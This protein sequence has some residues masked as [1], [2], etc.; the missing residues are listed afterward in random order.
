MTLPVN[1]TL[2][3]LALTRFNKVQ[4]GVGSYSRLMF[5]KEHSEHVIALFL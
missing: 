5:V 2:R 3:N 4:I 1:T